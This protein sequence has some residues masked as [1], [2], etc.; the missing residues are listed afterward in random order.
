MKKIPVGK[1]ENTTMAVTK[2]KKGLL[3]AAVVL[4]LLAAAA[5]VLAW[6]YWPTPEVTAEGYVASA[7]LTAPIFDEE[8]NA[9]G[10]LIRGSKVI[11]PGGK[12]TF[13]AG[14][15]VIV[16]TAGL[17]LSELEDIFA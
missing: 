15:S 13:Q 8:G 10:E 4:L 2:T 7:T 1:K 6:L 3:I 9:V 11:I 14:D 16:M 17:R 5:G 12:D